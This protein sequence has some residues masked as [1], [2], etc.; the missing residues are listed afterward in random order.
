MDEGGPGELGAGYPA[1]DLRFLEEEGPHLHRK[2]RFLCVLV[3]SWRESIQYQA[4][5]F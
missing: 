4:F 1:V 3:V 2:E 5:F